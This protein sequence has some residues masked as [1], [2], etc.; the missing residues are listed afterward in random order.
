MN[1]YGK[2]PMCSKWLKMAYSQNR[3]AFV[4]TPAIKFISRL[5]AGRGI[6]GA[7]CGDDGL[8]V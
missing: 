8:S 1:L 5:G 2:L 6:L 4:L 3:A 7:G